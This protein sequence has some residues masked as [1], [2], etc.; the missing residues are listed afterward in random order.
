[1]ELGHLKH[2]VLFFYILK[3]ENVID[4]SKPIYG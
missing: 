1:M 3:E 2:G 4:F